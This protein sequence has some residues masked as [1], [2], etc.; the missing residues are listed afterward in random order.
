MKKT[1]FNDIFSKIDKD[2]I[3]RVYDLVLK[4]VIRKTYLKQDKKSQQEMSKIFSSGP[5]QEKE[6]LIRK[7][8]PNFNEVFFEEFQN[9]LKELQEKL[10]KTEKEKN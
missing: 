8:F 9:F 7:Y 10:E 2:L 4:R 1:N 3:G 5:S 6:E